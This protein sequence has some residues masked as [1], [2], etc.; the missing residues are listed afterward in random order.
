MST[1]RMARVNDLIRRAIGEIILREV[2]DPRLSGL[3]SVTRVETSPDLRYAKV[4]VSLMGSDEEKRQA[5]D[6]LAAASGFLRRGLG[7]RVV[8]RYI[9]QLTF[10]LDDSIE[11]GSRMLELI[12]QVAP[13]DADTEAD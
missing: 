9:P 4:F 6:G 8:L 3:L 7:D 1:R 12:K 2:R 10:C 13:T 11:K 5:E